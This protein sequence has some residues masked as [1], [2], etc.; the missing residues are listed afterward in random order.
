MFKMV[1][2]SVNKKRAGRGKGSGLG[3]TAGFGLARKKNSTNLIF[4]GGQT[5]LAKTCRKYGRKSF[6][7]HKI[8]EMSLTNVP[9]NFK[10]NIII[11]NNIPCIKKEYVPKISFKYKYIN[12]IC[13]KNILK[14]KFNLDQKRITII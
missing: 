1:K 4:E 14:E 12:I 6:I 7:K 2:L 10:D 5:P 8:Y 13:N 3:R 9:E 11:N